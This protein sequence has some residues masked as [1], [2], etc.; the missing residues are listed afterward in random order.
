MKCVFRRTLC[1]NLFHYYLERSLYMGRVRFNAEYRNERVA[2]PW[3]RVTKVYA[4]LIAK[5]YWSSKIEFIC[6]SK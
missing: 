2:S 4:A 6:V 5:F 3:L 1:D